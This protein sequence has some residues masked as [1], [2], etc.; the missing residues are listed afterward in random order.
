MIPPKGAPPTDPGDPRAGRL[1]V[2]ALVAWALLL[3]VAYL[4]SLVIGGKSLHDVLVVAVATAVALFG[5]RLLADGRALD[6]AAAALE[7]PA[8][9]LLAVAVA[10][11]AI[12]GAWRA[13]AGLAAFHDLSIA[14]LFTQAFWSTLHGRVL[15]NSYEAVDGGVVSHFGVH[16]SPTLLLVTPFFA[17]RP[18]ARTLMA[19]QSAALALGAI[20][21]FALLRRR[22][23]GAGAL[24]LAGAMLV[25]PLFALAGGGDFHDSCFLVAPLLASVWALEAGRRR[26]L[27]VFVVLL[28][29]VREDTGLTV[30]AL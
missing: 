20:P 30:A 29:G 4:P 22:T 15:F 26:W 7:K 27:A 18:D 5:V 16:F 14:G 2:R 23:G 8:P 10:A 11:F 3:P 19:A 13:A 1:P 9:L 21:L 12:E 6:R 25:T 24:L 17:L 28:L